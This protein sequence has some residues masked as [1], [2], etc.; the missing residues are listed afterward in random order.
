M[1]RVE[2]LVAYAEQLGLES[3][4]LDLLVHDVAQEA[5][6]GALNSLEGDDAQEGHVAAVE[7]EAAAVNNGGLEA[8]VAFLLDHDS[9]DNV[10]DLLRQAADARPA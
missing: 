3:A 6:L 10:K 2:E 4:D 8:Q 9:A 1:T 5:G 7:A